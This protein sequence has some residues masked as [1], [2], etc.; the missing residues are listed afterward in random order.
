MIVLQIMPTVTI[1]F[2]DYA[3]DNANTYSLLLT[4]MASATMAM[5]KKLHY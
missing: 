4:F 3:A 5:V 1:L 2:N